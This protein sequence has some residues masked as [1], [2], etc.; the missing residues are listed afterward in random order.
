MTEELEDSLQKVFELLKLKY[1]VGLKKSKSIP[2]CCCHRSQK[3]AG[4]WDQF[5]L[6]GLFSG[7]WKASVLSDRKFKTFE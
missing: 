2:V 6:E 5:F 7:N 4:D 3:S 1:L